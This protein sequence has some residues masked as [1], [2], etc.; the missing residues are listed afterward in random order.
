MPVLL[1]ALQPAR[2][3]DALQKLAGAGILGGGEDPVWRALFED[4]AAVEE[5][6]AVDDV[7]REAH[8]VG[9]DEHGRAPRP[10]AP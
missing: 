3:D 5:A 1:K 4:P 7:A 10:R 2:G 9:G 8:L 6:H